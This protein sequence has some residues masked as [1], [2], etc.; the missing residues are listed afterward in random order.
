[1]GSCEINRRSVIRNGSNVL[2][3]HHEARV[4]EIKGMGDLLV[5]CNASAKVGGVVRK[6]GRQ[7][8][9]QTRKIKP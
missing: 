1:M 8:R 4:C 7:V 2:S 6:E 9:K 3:I 5:Q